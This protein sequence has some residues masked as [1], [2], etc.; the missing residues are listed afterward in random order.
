VVEICWRIFTNEE[1]VQ[2]FRKWVKENRPKDIS[3]PNDKGH[4]ARDWRV[5]LERLGMMRLLHIYPL[6]EME[7]GCAEGWKLY[8]RREWYKER[9]RAGELFRA[10]FPFLSKTDRPLSWATKGGR[11]R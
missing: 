2:S 6:S 5:A 10:L 1:I 3:G 8:R 9:R 7:A 11:S 4:K